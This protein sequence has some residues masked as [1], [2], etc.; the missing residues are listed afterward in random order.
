MY[1]AFEP[2][3]DLDDLLVSDEEEEEPG[4]QVDVEV[5]KELAAMGALWLWE[6]VDE[7]VADYM[8]MR[9]KVPVALNYTRARRARV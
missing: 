4:E 5:E 8:M 6:D 1:R 7:R 3:V 2:P 9:P